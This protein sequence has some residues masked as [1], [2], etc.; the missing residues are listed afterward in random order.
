M[1]EEPE[2]PASAAFVTAKRL[3]TKEILKH[4]QGAESPCGEL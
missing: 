4:L 2:T 3:L 1:E